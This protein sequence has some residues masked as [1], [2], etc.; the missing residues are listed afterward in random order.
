MYHFTDY[1]LVFTDVNIFIGK[2]DVQLN[3]KLQEPTL[4]V[5]YPVYGFEEDSLHHSHISTMLWMYTCTYLSLRTS[6]WLAIMGKL[7]TMYIKYTTSYQPAR[8]WIWLHCTYVW[9]EIW[10][11]C[12]GTNGLCHKYLYWIKRPASTLSSNFGAHQVVRYFE[13][14]S[15]PHRCEG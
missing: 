12:V 10:Q 15:A 9:M 1:L 5:A 4:Q 14:D 6:D 2:R 13:G 8:W 3:V 7:V 11:T